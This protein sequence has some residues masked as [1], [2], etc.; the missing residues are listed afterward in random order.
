MKRIKYFGYYDFLDSDDNRNIVLSAVNKMD[1][2]IDSLNDINIGVDIV[3]FSGINGDKWRFSNYKKISKGINTLYLF[4]AVSCPRI[5]KPIFRWLFTLY[6][7]LWVILHCAKGEQ[8]IVYHSLGYTGIF[9]FLRKILHL[10]IIGEIEEIYQDVKN[11]FSESKKKSE[12]EF[13][14][15]CTKYI[16]PSILLGN[17]INKSGKPELI[18]HGVYK[19]TCRYYG[20]FEDNKIHVVY[21]G[22]F[23]PNKGG[24]QIA[25]DAAK[26]LNSNFHLHLIGFG[27]QDDLNNIFR[28]IETIEQH[29]SA[30]VSYDGLLR[31]R[32]FDSFLQKCHI[33]LS[34]QNPEDDFND[35]SFPSKVLTYMAN[36]LKVV[37]FKI[38][39]LTTS[40]LDNL[41]YYPSEFS[42]KALA[43]TIMTIDVNSACNGNM[44]HELDAKFKTDLKSFLTFDTK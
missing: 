30:T 44:L 42:P 10:E 36:G 19:E 43:D 16:L 1:Y 9:N 22:T 23:D 35:T 24:A 4:P 5:F 21:A 31:G 13:I 38:K 17:K 18:V 41:L 7:I 27:S 39:V 6:F 33:G 25:L 20:K 32:E 37:S 34:P 2:I 29:A 12:F 28:A 15:N 14:E 8:V 11:S 26:Y 3:S 40:K